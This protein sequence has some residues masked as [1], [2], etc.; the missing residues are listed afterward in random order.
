VVT[1][2]KPKYTGLHGINRTQDGGLELPP[3]VVQE[4]MGHASIQ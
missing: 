4:R 1:I 3:K 2:V